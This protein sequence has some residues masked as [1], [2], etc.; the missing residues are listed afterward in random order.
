[1][2]D[3]AISPVGPREF[4]VEVSEGGRRTTHRVVVPESLGEGIELPADLE[5]V[6]R[7]SFRFLLEREPPSS[8]LSRFSL[9]DITGYFPE[10]PAELHARLA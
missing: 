2:A 5:R 1:M 3:I 7:E 8:I 10:Y 6:V 9:N 4:G